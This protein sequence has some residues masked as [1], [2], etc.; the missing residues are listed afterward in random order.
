MTSG[1]RLPVKIK[2]LKTL[3]V[4]QNTKIQSIDLP[5]VVTLSFTGKRLDHHAHS[6]VMIDF[7]VM[8]FQYDGLKAFD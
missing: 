6:T 4:E 1:F 3:T 7:K 5:E 8:Y 2:V